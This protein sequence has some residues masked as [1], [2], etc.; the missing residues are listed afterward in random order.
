MTLLDHLTELR[1]RL[2]ICVG[3]VIVISTITFGYYN[4]VSALILDPFASILAN[5]ATINVATIYEG[6]FVKM[7]LSII[8]GII[9]SLPIIVYQLCRFILPGLKS[10]EKKWL[11]LI[12][13]SSSFL[14]ILSTYVG[15]VIVLPYIIT[16]LLNSQ[17]VPDNINILLNYK[18]NLSY[19]MS[20]L[21][22]SIIIFQSPIVLTVCLAKD[23][24]SRQ[25]LLKNSRWFILGIIITSAMITP[26]DIF[27]QLSL[28]LPL[29]FIKK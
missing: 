19:V 28:S 18:Q 16:F 6:F 8:G 4:H 14:A 3:A 26:P 25:F 29:I 20:F 17:F 13:F 9:G 27:S 22:G 24:V 23:I 12:V 2:V 7:K 10:A 5:G 11:F 21:I 1:Q 15:F